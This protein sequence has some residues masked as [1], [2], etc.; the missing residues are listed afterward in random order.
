MPAVGDALVYNLPVNRG[1]G[2]PHAV[3]GGVAPSS[4]GMEATTLGPRYGASQLISSARRAEFEFRASF[5][6]CTQHDLKTTDINGNTIPGG[7]QSVT[8]PLLSQSGAT[9]AYFVPMTA[10]RPSNPYRIGRKMV[11]AFTGMLFSEGRWPQMRS[12]DPDT[13]AVAAEIDK[14]LELASVMIRARNQGGACGLVGVS[15]G[16]VNGKPFA[17]VHEGCHIEC[18]KWSE[19]E[20]NVPEHITE[21]YV[22]QRVR[23][24]PKTGKLETVDYYRRRD[25]TTKADIFFRDAEVTKDEPNWAE[26]FDESRTYVHN[27]GRIH[28]EWIANI[29]DDEVK[30]P[31]GQPDYAEAYEPMNTLDIVNSVLSQGAIR[32]LDPTLVVCADEE[33]IASG[34]IRKGSDNAITPGL[35]GKADY[36]TLP[37]GFIDS[38]IAVVQHNKQQILDTCECVLADPD[39]LAASGMSSVALK[40]VYAPMIA[41]CDI[42]RTQYGRA[43]GNIINGLIDYARM[44]LPDEPGQL[45]YGSEDVPFVDDNGDPIPDEAPEEG[46]EAADPQPVEFFLDLPPRSI[47]KPVYD[48][49]GALV[50][51]NITT[52]PHQLGQGDVTLEWGEY[53]RPTADDMQKST[54]AI[55]TATGGQKVISQRAAV[56]LVANIYNRD[57]DQAWKEVSDE[58]AEDRRH[59]LESASGM[60][61]REDGSVQPPDKQPEGELTDEAILDQITVNEARA[62]R[63]YGPLKTQDGADNPDG[64]LP[65]AEYKAKLAAKGTVEGETEAGAPPDAGGASV[66]P[67]TQEKPFGGGLEATQP[68]NDNPPKP[69]P[70]KPGA[71][72]KA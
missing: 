45:V 52:E 37:A 19:I 28:F 9:P 16:W 12:T 47:E 65:I 46:A 54:T 7:R 33:L 70:L 5:Y 44:H 35:N 69:Q 71:D 38:G 43:I 51:K 15:W 48:A 41:K 62:A 26:Y 29:P 53:F 72:P 4:F 6:R 10:R 32:N 34:L 23:P 13:Q 57:P 50:E 60:Y 56:E 20:K 11:S 18:L 61:P 30:S 55:A 39:K 14:T 17:E 42:M 31:D 63:G 27:H 22:I 67:G 2:G 3:V 58:T 40:I 66:P 1:D 49:A 24:N 68:A 21:I 64:F 8:Q 36:L 59:E 25:W